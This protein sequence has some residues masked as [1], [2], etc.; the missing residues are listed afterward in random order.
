MLSLALHPHRSA[1][2]DFGHIEAREN[3]ND[4][5][6]EDERDEASAAGPARRFEP[7]R[8][9]PRRIIDIEQARSPPTSAQQPDAGRD[10]RR[11]VGAAGK[12]PVGA[13][14]ARTER[15]PF[16]TTETAKPRRRR[17]SVDEARREARA[18]PAGLRTSLYRGAGRCRTSLCRD[19]RA[20]LRGAG[21]L[22]YI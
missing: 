1:A 15:E 21:V 5:D 14:L 16:R 2:W 11:L 17:T 10:N 19:A 9:T 6:L 18:S 20:S 13:R 7:Q 12:S 4:L 8:S 3:P 22:S